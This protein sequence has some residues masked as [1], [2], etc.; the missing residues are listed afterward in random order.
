MQEASAII[1]NKMVANTSNVDLNICIEI[2][3]F[4]NILQ[5]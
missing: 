4:E 5:R 3:R 2:T 1:H